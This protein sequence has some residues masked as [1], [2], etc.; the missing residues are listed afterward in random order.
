MKSSREVGRRASIAFDESRLAAGTG[1]DE[2]AGEPGNAARHGDLQVRV[3]PPRLR[4]AVS[5]VARWEGGWSR[6]H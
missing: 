2:G 6:V 5:S 3:L 1:E 4:R